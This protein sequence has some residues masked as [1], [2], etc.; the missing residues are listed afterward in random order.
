MQGASTPHPSLA[1]PPAPPSRTRPAGH[2]AEVWGDV[3]DLRHLA[4]AVVIGAAVSLGTYL[5]AARIFAGFIAV[6]AVGQAYAML[7]GLVGCLVS[8]VICARLFAPKREVLETAADPAWRIAA[9]EQ[10]AGETGSIGSVA[11]LPPEVAAE[12]KE[13]GLYDLFASYDGDV[14]QTASRPQAATKGA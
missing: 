14:A 5:V 6:A 12:M 9:L 13:L 2:L 10:L 4:A 7:V 3:V 8:G 1:R 11:D